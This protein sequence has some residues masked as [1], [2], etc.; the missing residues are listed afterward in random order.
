MLH[1]IV[2]WFINVKQNIVVTYNTIK[3]M[4]QLSINAVTVYDFKM[5]ILE[6]NFFHLNGNL[7][8][9]NFVSAYKIVI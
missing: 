2:F 5:V 9:K 3:N 4:Y 7:F 8:I 6:N 1:K